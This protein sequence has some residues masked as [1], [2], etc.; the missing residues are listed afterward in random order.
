MASSQEKRPPSVL[1]GKNA[2]PPEATSLVAQMRLPVEMGIITL[3]SSNVA[4]RVRGA[5][6]GA[7]KN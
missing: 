4:V 5:R 3:S 6:C 1:S 7:I 2:P